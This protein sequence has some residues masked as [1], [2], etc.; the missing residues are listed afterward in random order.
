MLESVNQKLTIHQLAAPSL[1]FKCSAI[2]YWCFI[3]FLL[4]HIHEIAKSDYFHHVYLSAGNNHCS[5]LHEM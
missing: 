5:Y 4:R 1:S 3:G 2:N